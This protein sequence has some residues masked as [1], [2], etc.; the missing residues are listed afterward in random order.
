MDDI[1]Y[2]TSIGL[3]YPDPAV[4]M[5]LIDTGS[6]FTIISKVLAKSSNL[7]LTN[8]SF[9]IRTLNGIVSVRS[10]VARLASQAPGCHA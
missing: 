7:F 3:E 5:A 6:P 9:P 1:E 8:P 4:P 2:G 10:I